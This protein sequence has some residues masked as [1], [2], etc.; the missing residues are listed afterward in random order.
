MVIMV[1]RLAKLGILVDSRFIVYYFITFTPKLFVEKIKQITKIQLYDSYLDVFAT[2]PLQDVLRGH[3]LSLL[4]TSF[5]G[6]HPPRALRD[7]RHSLI[8]GT[9][10]GPIPV[11]LA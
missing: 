3:I 8:P 10:H 11:S 4:P 9:K 2:R 7:S 1:Y 6:L 5:P